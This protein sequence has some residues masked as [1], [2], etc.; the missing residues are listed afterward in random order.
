[1]VYAGTYNNGLV[2][3]DLQKNNVS[4]L[5]KKDGL[6]SNNISE[7]HYQDS[8]LFVKSAQGINL[9]KEKKIRSITEEDGLSFTFLNVSEI[10]HK[11]TFY[12]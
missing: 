3:F 10:F 6:L 9:I 1:M 7:I 2:M 12:L 11:V 5:S 8:T 4:S